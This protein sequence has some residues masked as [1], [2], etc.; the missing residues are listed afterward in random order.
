MSDLLGWIPGLLEEL[1][2]AH[3]LRARR[4]VVSLPDGWCE[5]DGRRLRNFAGNDYLGLAQHPRLQQ[6]A[7]RALA[8]AGCGSGA[9]P[10]VS[11]RSRW[12]VE[13][14]ETLAWFEH[15]EAAVVFPTGYAANLGVIPAVVSAG[16]DDVVFCDRLNHASLVDGCRLSG[17]RL[18]IFRHTEL[19]RLGQELGRCAGA[20]RRVIVSD[21]VFSMDGDL[22]PL[23]EL[24]RLA[25]EH[26]ALLVVDEAHGTGVWGPTGR[27]VCEHFQV[28][29]E[30]PVRIGTLS[31]AVG[32]LGGFV[33]GEQILID[34]LWNKARTQI[35]STAL[36]PPVCAA[37][38][39]G[40]RVIAESPEL[41]ERLLTRC[42]R[43]RELLAG[44]GLAPLPGADGPI[45]PLLLDD[46]QTALTLGEQLAQRGY[47]V[48]TI[49][50]PTVPRGTSRLRISLS[51]VHDDEALSGLA[52]ALAEIWPAA[53]PRRSSPHAAG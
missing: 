7:L 45:I 24:V 31:K 38:T 25:R 1:G 29:R 17:A 53:T 32:A 35:Y 43:F 8:E 3:L 51:A 46:P 48:G 42:R 52:Q 28:E 12:M 13:L 47:L 14:E 5:I 22:A 33:V 44:Q 26:G 21:G 30:V 40:L 10:L 39:E 36:P 37:A 6:V 16:E 34:W 2:Q 9:S 41:R 15:S 27:G 4:Q 50:P 19:E 49:R 18:R 23:P 11:G 20:R